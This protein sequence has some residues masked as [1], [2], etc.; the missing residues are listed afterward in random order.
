MNSNQ[1]QTE[2]F[3][4]A[5]GTLYHKKFTEYIDHRRTMTLVDYTD[6]GKFNQETDCPI[7]YECM[8]ED[9]KNCCMTGNNCEHNICMD[10]FLRITNQG[11]NKCPICRKIL[12][13]DD[14]E[15]EEEQDETEDETEE[16]DGEYVFTGNNLRPNVDLYIGRRWFNIETNTIEYWYNGWSNNLNIRGFLSDFVN[17]FRNGYDNNSCSVCGIQRTR[18]VNEYMKHHLANGNEVFIAKR[19]GDDDWDDYFDT[20]DNNLK[21][22]FGCYEIYNRMYEAVEKEIIIINR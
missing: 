21:Y 19:G 9:E 8:I 16:E 15:E 18:E 14:E 17:R 7:C 20:S 3:K 13:G 11:N 6:T 4:H 5:L 1:I 10:C 22:C 2:T 12:N